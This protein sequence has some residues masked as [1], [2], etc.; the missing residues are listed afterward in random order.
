[1]DMFEAFWAAFNYKKD[2]KNAITAFLA[3]RNIKD[4]YEKI[5]HG[6]KM[7]AK[8]RKNNPGATPKMAQGWLNDERWNDYE[9]YRAEKESVI[10]AIKEPTKWKDYWK[11][12]TGSHPEREWSE[13]LQKTQKEIIKGMKDSA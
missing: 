3:I 11:D 6:A 4:E 10:E 1:M 7:E 2:R 9:H 12:Y 5:I 8:Q 13:L